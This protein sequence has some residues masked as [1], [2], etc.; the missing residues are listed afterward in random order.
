MLS[1]PLQC[2]SAPQLRSVEDQLSVRSDVVFNEVGCYGVAEAAALL[3]ATGITGNPAE[4]VITKQ[5]NERST[6]SVAR[7]YR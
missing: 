3:A 1:L 2:Y 5:K 4:L 6:I 7:S